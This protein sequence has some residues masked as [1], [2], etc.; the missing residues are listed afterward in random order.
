M[1]DSTAH[2]GV[3]VSGCPTV[4]IGDAST[5]ATLGNLSTATT[6][7][8]GQQNF[9]NCGI[10]SAQQI[11]RQSTGNNVSENDM[12]NRALMKGW[13]DSGTPPGG[14]S[15]DTRQKILADRGVKSH[16][17][18]QTMEN[19]TQDVAEGRGVITSHDAGILWNDPRYVGS[20]HAVVVTGLKYDKD[21]KLE[22]VIIN[23]TG[24]GQ[25]GK[26]IPAKQFQ[27]S[28]RPNRDINVT[29]DPIW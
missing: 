1:G 3:I 8:P 29:D 6:V 21:G 13:A 11:V 27:D 18:P 20:G 19:I 22:K 24:D 25:A 23:D 15:P 28:L 17:E 16:L 14:T 4:L 12:F 10:Q 2:G 26:E 9:N 7:F 5:G